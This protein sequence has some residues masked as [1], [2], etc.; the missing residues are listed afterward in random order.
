MSDEL[1]TLV[2]RARAGD[3][4]SLEQ[5]VLRVQRPIY[6]LAL[7]M[8]W[9]P[10]DARDA[11]QEILIR[12]ITHLGSFRG[13]S[14]FLTW[15]YRISANYLITVR[16]SRVEAQGYTLER[17][18]KDL[19]EG[20]AELPQGTGE[21]PA[22][23]A[24]LLEEVKI[25]CMHALLTCLDRA[26]RLAYI[27]GEILELEGPEAARI[28]NTWHAAF[29]KRV[30]R[31]REAIIEFTRAQCGLVNPTNACR[32]ARRL[33]RAQAMGR[34]NATALMFAQPDSARAFPEL[35]ERVRRLEVVRRTAAL[36]RCSPD[37]DPSPELL[38]RVR[39]ALDLS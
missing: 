8:L 25:G 6:N 24:L 27:L 11:T 23:K 2:E 36:Y 17:F 32:C 35:L 3:R 7:R 39:A 33:P 5:V 29:R 10:E 13:D 28:L 15:A 22:D 30:S 26:H 9:H 4:E 20:R 34:V 16:Q 12:I 37:A 14:R 21:W 38:A 19:H 1:E 18:A 31:A